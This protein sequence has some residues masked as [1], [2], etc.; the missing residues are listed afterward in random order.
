MTR[1]YANTGQ[2]DEV[3]HD[4]VSPNKLKNQTQKMTRKN[5]N[6]KHLDKKDDLLIR[7]YFTESSY[8]LT[9]CL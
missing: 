8:N 4:D 1:S 6:R 5:K 2:R 3:T 9:R 7:M